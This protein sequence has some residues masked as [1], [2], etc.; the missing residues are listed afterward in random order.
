MTPE[1][2]IVA[3]LALALGLLVGWL[4]AGRRAGALASDLAVARSRADDADLL[5]QTRDAVERERNTAMQDL[6]SLRA[7]A[8]ERDAAYDDAAG[9]TAAFN[10]NLLVR[11]RRELGAEVDLD[12]FAHRAFFNP[13]PSRIEMHLVSSRAQS[14]RFGDHVFAFAEGETIH[15]EN[16]YKYTLEGFRALATAAG[17]TPRAVWTDPENL[18]SVHALSRT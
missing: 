6:A 11:M 5:R 12:A 4:M 7:R 13:E 9:V 2:L 1:L 14:I 17:W 18:F 10:R 16:S 3:L 8:A 15:T